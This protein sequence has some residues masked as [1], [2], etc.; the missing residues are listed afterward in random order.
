MPKLSWENKYY[1]YKIVLR[2]PSTLYSTLASA[3][4]GF[5]VGSRIDL[6]RERLT[7]RAKQ[8][9]YGELH[10]EQNYSRY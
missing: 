6:R 8:V 5:A 7:H 9:H 2:I 3:G 10:Q 4:L 1:F